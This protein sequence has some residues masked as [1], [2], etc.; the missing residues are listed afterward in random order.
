MRS[1][2]RTA[3]Q[4]ARYRAAVRNIPYPVQAVWAANDPAMTLVG[5][6][7]NAGAAQGL[8]TCT[9]HPVSSSRSR[10]RRPPSPAK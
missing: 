8:P 3:A 5:Y 7:E 6:G 10:T 4:Q 1:T 9:P 2:E